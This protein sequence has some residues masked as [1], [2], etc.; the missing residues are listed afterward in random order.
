MREDPMRRISA[1]SDTVTTAKP[2]SVASN[3]FTGVTIVALLYFAREIFVPLVIAGLLSFVM[4]PLVLFFRRLRTGRLG[5]ALAAVSLVVVLLVGLAGMMTEQLTQLLQNVP[6]YEQTISDKVKSLQGAA[7]RPGILDGLSQMVQDL[8]SYGTQPPI[9]NKGGTGSRLRRRAPAGTAAEPVTVEIEK[10]TTQPFE[11][12]ETW[13]GPVLGLMARSGIVLVFMLFMLLFREDL[14]DRFVRLAGA[15]DLGRTSAAMDDAGRRLSRYFLIQISV[16]ASFG[17]IIGVGLW[18]IGIPNPILWAVFAGVMRFVPYIGAVIGA[19][20][21]AVLAI[22]VDPGWSMLIWTLGLFAV[23]ELTLGQLIEPL[24]Y[25]RHTGLSPVAVIVAAAFWT[26][27]WG[28]IGLLLSMPLTVCVMVLGRHVESFEFLHVILGDQPALTPPQSF[29]QRILAGD[30]HEAADQAETFMKEHSLCEFY[31]QIAVPAFVIARLETLRGPVE[32]GR[33]KRIKDT[34]AEC[35]EDLSDHNEG[36]SKAEPTAEEDRKALKPDNLPPRSADEPEGAKSVIC[37][38][39]RDPLDEAAAAMLAQILERDGFAP[40]IEPSAA[41]SVAH[42]FKPDAASVFA[43]CVVY[44][45]GVSAVHRRYL[46]RR[47][48]RKMPQALLVVVSLDGTTHVDGHVDSSA[49]TTEAN[50]VALSCRE[51]VDFCIEAAQRPRAADAVS[52]YPAAIAVGE[53]IPPIRT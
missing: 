53:T 12:L 13:G 43:V 30:P 48:R 27:L 18:L 32:P 17:V 40:Q 37:V 6:Q 14:R 47:L 33:L 20:M 8:G 4:A 49:V 35:I 23:I 45:G 38:A 10:P 44:L 25:G 2:T 36:S 50:H 34:F 5:A 1:A 22:A 42:L 11:T 15:Q 21:P 7:H 26:W 51:A 28:P 16:N 31:D 9:L 19:F 46:F 24:L 41:A 39:A 3:L 52:Q 29:I